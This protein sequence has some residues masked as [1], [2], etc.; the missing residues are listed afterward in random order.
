MELTIISLYSENFEGFKV[1]VAK[2]DDNLP[3]LANVSYA[4]KRIYVSELFV[5]TFSQK[6]QEAILYHEV[7][8]A[9]HGHKG[10]GRCFAQELEADHYAAIRVGGKA[11]L[12]SLKASFDL[13]KSLPLNEKRKKSMTEFLDRYNAMQELVNDGLV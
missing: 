6:V 12:E 8:H 7:G 1:R 13:I 2:R 10:D 5:N 9:F 4:T 11:V 3:F